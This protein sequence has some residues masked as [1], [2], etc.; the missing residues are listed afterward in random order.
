M[1]PFILLASCFTFAV[2]QVTTADDAL[3]KNSA[4]TQPVAR[5]T[6][7]VHP[8]AVNASQ[9]RTAAP[10]S[11]NVRGGPQLF[12][13]Q[14]RLASP[15]MNVPSPSRIVPTRQV[16]DASPQRVVANASGGSVQG[17]NNNRR[18]YFDALQR[19]RHERHDG[20]WWRQHFTT[21]VFVS[22]AYYYL[23]A[24]Y[25][26]PAL[27]YDPA[28]DYYDYDGPIYTYG[29]LLP[30]QVIANVQSALQQEGYYFGPVTGSLAPATR[31]AIAKYQIDH[32]LILTGAIDEPTIVSLGLT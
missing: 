26:Y 22:T 23:D 21:I 4:A 11:Q 31:A 9:S 8:S 2:A 3:P 13:Q 18:S 32:G 28:N 6:S 27:G 12:P 15:S 17:A 29:N 20:N 25:W 16:P 1:K 10:P 19:C 14:T 30:D 5:P 7:S 24:G